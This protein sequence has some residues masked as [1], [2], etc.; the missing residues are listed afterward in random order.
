MQIHMR[1]SMANASVSKA[2]GLLAVAVLT[3]VVL[4]GSDQKNGSLNYSPKDNLPTGSVKNIEDVDGFSGSNI[5]VLQL[6][7]DVS[8]FS[9]TPHI[10]GRGLHF[11]LLG[12][13]NVLKVNEALLAKPLPVVSSSG[14]NIGYLGHINWIGPQADWWAYQAENPSRLAEKANWPPDAHTVL[15]TSTIEAITDRSASMTL[16]ASPITG[17]A[18]HK[19]FVLRDDGSLQLDVTATNTRPTP[20]AWDIWFNT[21]LAANSKLYVPV[22]SNRDVRVESFTPS[23]FEGAVQLVEG[24]LTIDTAHAKQLKG[25]VFVQPSKG[26]MAAFTENQL[27]VI[28]F[29]LQPQPSIHPKQG[30]LEF[31]LDYNAA[32]VD[33]GL[34][35]ME[36]HSPYSTLGPGQTMVSQEVWRVYDYS[37][38]G[39]ELGLVKHHHKR[40]EQLGYK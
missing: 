19:S 6:T 38:E 36:L 27:F 35:E 8:T 5:Q 37:G 20:V 33:V 32:N 21:R 12:K 40:L 14:E 18:L 2:L 11:G 4:I 28:E 17:L 23:R 25:K 24:L 31:Y 15:A 39:D 29:A 1:A 30:Q 7:N 34:L 16:P 9:F 26:W 22:K 3:G 13:P 10:G